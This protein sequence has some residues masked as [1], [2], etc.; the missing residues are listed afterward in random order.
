MEL[1]DSKNH[2]DVK[3]LFFAG[4][5]VSSLF[6]AETKMF[7]LYKDKLKIKK[8]PGEAFSAGGFS[9]F[10][11]IRSRLDFCELDFLYSVVVSMVVDFE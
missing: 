8:S 1:S 2:D 5:A 3:I 9:C 11:L 4:Y 10:C 7:A 6:D